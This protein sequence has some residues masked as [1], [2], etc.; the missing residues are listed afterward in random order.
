MINKLSVLENQ[1][2]LIVLLVGAV[3]LLGWATSN[4]DIINIKSA[5]TNMKASTAIM[6]VLYGGWALSEIGWMKRG[7]YSTSVMIA[8]TTVLG[9][10][11]ADLTLEESRTAVPPIIVCMLL[12]IQPVRHWATG[13]ITATI[14]AAAILGHA[15]AVPLLYWHTQVTQGMSP[16]TA[17]LLL[18][19]GCVTCRAVSRGNV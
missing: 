18:M 19:I 13:A 16:M 11:S 10:I 4:N 15:I 17:M 3:N 5:D 6:F 7:F 14:A 12:I 8:V 9:R 1:I 2:A